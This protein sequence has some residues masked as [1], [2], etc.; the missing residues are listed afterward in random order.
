MTSAPPAVERTR[1]ASVM[2]AGD[3][4]GTDGLFAIEAGLDPIL[5]ALRGA[6]AR[7]AAVHTAT[8]FAGQCRHRQC[9]PDRVFAPQRGL[10]NRGLGA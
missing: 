2:T 1:P 6:G 9:F 7:R 8:P 10:A 4:D 3:A 5:V